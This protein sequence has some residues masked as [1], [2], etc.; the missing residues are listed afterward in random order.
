MKKNNRNLF[1]IY[2]C[3]NLIDMSINRWGWLGE[4]KVLCTL[5]HQGVQLILASSW[6]KPAV[7]A[8]GKGRGDCFYF[9][10]FFTV[11]H[12]HFS[13]VPSLSSPLLSLLSLFSLSLGDNTGPTKVD[14]SLNPNTINQVYKQTLFSFADLRVTG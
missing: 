4:A 12:F 10:C 11:I 3:L 9:F 2:L 14:V 7:L 1:N 13:A 6:A 8:A 5:R